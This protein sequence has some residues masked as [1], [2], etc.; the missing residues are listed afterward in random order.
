MRGGDDTM[1]PS[2]CASA[3]K[4][5]MQYVVIDALAKCMNCGYFS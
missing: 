1:A 5:L 2:E 4:Q 3:N